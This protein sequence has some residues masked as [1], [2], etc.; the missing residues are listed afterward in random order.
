MRLAQVLGGS[1]GGHR[2]GGDGSIQLIYGGMR[3]CLWHLVVGL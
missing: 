1:A 3:I 2:L